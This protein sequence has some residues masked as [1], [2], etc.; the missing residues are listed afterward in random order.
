M[1]RYLTTLILGKPPGGSSPVLS[2]HSFASNRKLALL[3]SAKEVNYVPDV[4]IAGSLRV[5][6]TR[7]GQS[8]CAR[9]YCK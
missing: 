8:Y 1:V 9:Y 6:R 5:K 2:A 4:T 3:E 7:Y